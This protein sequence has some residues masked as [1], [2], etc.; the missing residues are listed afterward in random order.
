MSV[1]TIVIGESGTGKSAS[2]RNFDPNNTLLIQSVK[3]PLPFRTGNWRRI[4]RDLPAGGNIFVC[5]Q[6]DRIIKFMQRTSRKIIVLDDFQYILA[7][8]FMR[9]SAETGFQKFSDIGRHA[10]D[11]LTAA[12]NL[13]DDVRVYIL[14]H[15]QSDEFG[16]TK[17][18]TIGK[19]LDEKI[20]VEG[21]VSIVLRTMVRDGHYQFT[22]RNSGSDTVKTPMGLFEDEVIDNCL[23]SV[24]EAICKYY[25]MEVHSLKAAA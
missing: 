24:D 9:R 14:A 11:I 22:T 16:N 10:W 25:G 6:S 3:K 13:P 1:T 18:K 4:E 12:A 15:S 8:E 17:L 2:M 21:M 19:L 7:N 5:D 20:T 23:A